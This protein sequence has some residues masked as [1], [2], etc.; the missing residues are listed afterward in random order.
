MALANAKVKGIPNF[1]AVF[2]GT[3]VNLVRDWAVAQ[4]TD[5]AVATVAT[6]QHLSWNYR[7]VVPALLDPPRFPLKTRTLTAGSQVSLT[8]NGGA[9]AYLRFGVAGGV[10][11]KITGTSTGAALPARVSLTVVRTK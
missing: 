6:F 9:A 1:T 10:T 8:L 5:D 4:Y 2:G 7:S 3:F 11:G